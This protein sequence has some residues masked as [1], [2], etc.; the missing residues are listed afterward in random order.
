MMRPE[1]HKHHHWIY[2]GCTQSKYTLVNI[3]ICKRCGVEKRVTLD[4]LTK[5][6]IALIYIKDCKDFSKAPF[7]YTLENVIF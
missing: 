5:S 6:F 2:K 1:R 7:C 3:E 4:K